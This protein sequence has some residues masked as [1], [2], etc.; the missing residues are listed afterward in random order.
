MYLVMIYL[1]VRPALIGKTQGSYTDA[2]GDK[3]RDF[4]LLEVNNL[5]FIRRRFTLPWSSRLL[6]GVGSRGFCAFVAQE[7][8]GRY[9][10]HSI[11]GL[12]T[13]SA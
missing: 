8:W 9:R 7:S 11:F 3:T 10:S 4:Q 5:P 6:E 13:T 12:G 1:E 2:K